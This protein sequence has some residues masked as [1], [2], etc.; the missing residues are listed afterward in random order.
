MSRLFA[1]KKRLRERELAELVEVKVVSSREANQ[2]QASNGNAIE[3]RLDRGC[4]HVVEPGCDASY[5]RALLAL[6]V[7]ES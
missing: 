7:S 2:A 1:W 6:L 5:L 4:S 3:M